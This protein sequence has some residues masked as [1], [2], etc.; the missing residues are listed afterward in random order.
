[1]PASRHRAR[2][3]RLASVPA[4]AAVA[5][6]AAHAL[7]A[8]QVI[9]VDAAGGPGSDYADLD[10]AIAAANAGDFLLLR[11]GEY[12]PAA[13]ITNRFRVN[14]SLLLHGE[15]EAEVKLRG[16]LWVED[17]AASGWFTL[18]GVDVAQQLAP[19]LAFDDLSIEDCAGPVRI[20]DA[21]I[22]P[23]TPF[24]KLLGSSVARSTD[25][26][27]ARVALSLGLPGL[28]PAPLFG[29]VA[30]E[31]HESRG[32]L[33]DTS[34]ESFTA[35][36]TTTAGAPGGDGVSVSGTSSTLKSRLFVGGSIVAASDGSDGSA[37]A[38]GCGA[39]GNGGCAIQVLGNQAQLRTLDSTFIA[40]A[41][42]AA[43]APCV[44]GE[45]GLPVEL[46]VGQHAA[47]PGV[48]RSLAASSPIR[49]GQPLVLDAA[50]LG[51]DLV[52]LAYSPNGGYA[53]LH[54]A[55]G[56]LLLAPPLSTFALPALPGAPAAPAARTY[57]SPTQDLGAGVEGALLRFQAVFVQ[58][59]GDVF[60]SNE[61][62][63][64]LLDASL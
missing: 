23:G 27:L 45:P 33:H 37:D 38:S 15:A 26:A 55:I 30:L 16:A 1:M 18:R 56:P 60:L 11:A 31:W 61:S 42:G 6:L 63:V 28:H 64:L 12:F 13:A 54:S 8:Q 22:G 14:K 53:E 57:A 58:P 25:V 20:E 48:A 32:S 19:F 2:R 47:H 24:N 39:G 35:T 29:L 41:G 36:S 3:G 21:E 10:A 40:G 9:V 62:D 46:A 7:A 59:S 44:P 5:A 34:I 51:G 49:E 43:V 17:I 50:G 52:I 4:R